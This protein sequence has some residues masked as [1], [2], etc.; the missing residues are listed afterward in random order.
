M[1]VYRALSVK[2]SIWREREREEDGGGGGCKRQVCMYVWVGGGETQMER[3]F[4][5]YL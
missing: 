4:E 1:S 3:V 5:E 2:E